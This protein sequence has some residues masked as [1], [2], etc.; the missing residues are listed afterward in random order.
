MGVG[1]VVPVIVSS[2]FVDSAFH[3]LTVRTVLLYRLLRIA[4]HGNALRFDRC[5]ARTPLL[6][7]LERCDFATRPLCDVLG[8]VPALCVRHDS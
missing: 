2:S 3:C 7:R 8:P 4:D 1:F 6:S 5:V